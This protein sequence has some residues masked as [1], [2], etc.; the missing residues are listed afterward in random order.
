VRLGDTIV[1]IASAPGR[2][3]RGLV[4]LSGPD[5]GGIV[6]GVLGAASDP[7]RL[8]AGRLDLAGR[9]IACLAWWAPG[10]G[11]YTGEDSAELLL[12]GNPALLRRVTTALARRADVRLASAGEFT[13]RAFLHGRISLDDAE[14]VAQTIAARNE[15]ELEAARR[16]GRGASGE[17]VRAALE[18]LTDTLADVEAGID[19]SD[20]DG[21]D[22][23][24]PGAVAQRVHAI[25]GR[26]D[27]L[28]GGPAREPERDE[29]MVALVGRPNSGKSTLFNALLGQERA[30]TSRIAGST[31]DAL[32]EPLDLSGCTPGG[33][34]VDLVDLAGLTEESTSM[35]EV[36]AQADVLVWCDPSAAFRPIGLPEA[37]AIVRVRTMADRPSGAPTDPG[38]LAVC[39]LDGFNLRALRLAVAQAAASRGP[40]LALVTPRR[41]EALDRARTA[42][43]RAQRACRTP[44]ARR[45]LELVAADLRL[46]LDALGELA[47]RVSP[48]DV[49]GRIFATFCIGK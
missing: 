17:D 34:R 40:R 9:S 7:R 15:A 3:A 45:D 38:P 44:S 26:I 12:P 24:T 10:P 1:A 41:Q 33:P 21:V 30:V 25:I 43:E 32:V 6:K 4:R 35:R 28:G 18:D 31:R 23:V 11:T 27:G 20:Q 49:I 2:S 39:A 37:A 13:A 29:P 8:S 19:F 5:A 16:I 46:A 14:A 22:T 36:I 48:D 47:G 42:L